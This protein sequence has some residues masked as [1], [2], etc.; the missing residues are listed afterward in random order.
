MVQVEPE[1]NPDHRARTKEGPAF[2]V[3]EKPGKAAKRQANVATERRSPDIMSFFR[4]SK[5]KA[6]PSSSRPACAVEQVNA[7]LGVGDATLAE[8][9]P[10][11][12]EIQ[13]PE[14]VVSDMTSI[15]AG[16]SDKTSPQTPRKQVTA[17]SHDAD[18]I[19]P[20]SVTHRRRRGGKVSKSPSPR[21]RRRTSLPLDNFFD[22]LTRAGNESPTRTRPETSKEGLPSEPTT[23]LRTAFS[24]EKVYAVPRESLNGTWKELDLD[25]VTS[26]K[27]R[28]TARVSYV[29]LADD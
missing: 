26:V 24:T 27:T 9:D 13:M 19:L 29:N 5:A 6:G 22:I 3:G 17:V 11:A 8:A 14:M 16:P 25:E 20:S 10:F 15:R 7:E 23:G 1:K 2:P 28:R 21:K 18:I 12:R 4:S